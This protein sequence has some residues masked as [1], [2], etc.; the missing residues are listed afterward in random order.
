[1]ATIAQLRLL[2]ELMVAHRKRIARP[3]ASKWYTR[4]MINTVRVRA[5]RP[6]LV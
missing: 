2:E 5:V 1:M 4:D 6:P 3:D